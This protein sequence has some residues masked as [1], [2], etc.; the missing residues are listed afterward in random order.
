MERATG[1][2]LLE[3]IMVIVII[4]ILAALGG[5]LYFKTVERSRIAEAKRMLGLIRMAQLRYYAEHAKFTPE[6]NE[7]DIDLVNGKYFNIAAGVTIGSLRP[8]HGL[9]NAPSA[10]VCIGAVLRNNVQNPYGKNYALRILPNGDICHE[11]ANWPDELGA[12]F[13]KCK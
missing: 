6:I 8:G 2:T 1:F 4:G 13:P 3:L 10:N 7:L 5:P 9:A 11:S 12:L